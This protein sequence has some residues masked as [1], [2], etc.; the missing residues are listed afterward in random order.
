MRGFRLKI[1]RQRRDLSQWDLSRLTDISPY[2]I[3]AFERER[4]EPR[5]GE[6][7]RILRALAS[8]DPVW[9]LPAPEK[10]QAG[11]AEPE[12]KEARPGGRP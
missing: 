8:V 3:G 5:P 2:R 6:V 4:A 12:A 11:P 7:Q 1:E 9:S 10:D